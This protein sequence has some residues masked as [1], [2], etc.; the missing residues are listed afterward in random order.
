[1]RDRRVTHPAAEA[2]VLARERAAVHGRDRFAVLAEKLARVLDDGSVAGALVDDLLDAR[3]A[4][5]LCLR[6]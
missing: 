2:A 3:A 6:R 5:K 4:H 1:M